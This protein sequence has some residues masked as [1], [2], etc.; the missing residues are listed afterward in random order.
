M[1][2]IEPDTHLID[3][4]IDASSSSEDESP[5]LN[6]SCKKRAP[7]RAVAH[8]VRAGERVHPSS[9]YV[10]SPSHTRAQTAK[11]EAEVLQSFLVAPKE[12]LALVALIES[13]IGGGDGCG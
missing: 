7:V 13:G 11:P 3:P 10:G 4:P 12:P 9:A 8:F 5:Q 2:Q 1:E 6:E